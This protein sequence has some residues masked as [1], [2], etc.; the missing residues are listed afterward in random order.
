MHNINDIQLLLNDNPFI[1]FTTHIHTYTITILDAF[2]CA[3]EDQLSAK[4]VTQWRR[5]RTYLL[6]P[7]TQISPFRFDNSTKR[8]YRVF[9]MPSVQNLVSERCGPVFSENS[10]IFKVPLR[11]IPNRV[12]V[13]IGG[14]RQSSLCN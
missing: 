6:D 10:K 12:T 1:F 2:G 9:K 3:A 11:N 5:N 13:R 4:R 8:T 14:L 7:N